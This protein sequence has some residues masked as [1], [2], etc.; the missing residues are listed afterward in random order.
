M[1][2]GDG[3]RFRS[4]IILVEKSRE[5]KRKFVW[6]TE[7]PCAADK[8]V[9]RSVLMILTNNGFTI[10]PQLGRWIEHGHKPNRWYFSLT[11]RKLY[12][13]SSTTNV[14]YLVFSSVTFSTP[15]RGW[16]F[17]MNG[18]VSE[19]PGDVEKATV[20]VVD[21]DTVIYEGCAEIRIEQD[22]DPRTVMDELNRFEKF[23]IFKNITAYTNWEEMAAG[24]RD[25]KLLCISD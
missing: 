12:K 16:S 6:S 8:R 23:Y 4:N 5:E 13:R 7:K 15:R 18:V 25:G 9:W 20:R 11:T 21:I 19:L 22:Q 1:T 3:T 2:T 24:I 10:S 17:N 14:T